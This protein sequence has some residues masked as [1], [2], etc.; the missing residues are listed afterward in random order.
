MNYVGLVL[1]VVFA[2]LTAAGISHGQV[3]RVPYASLSPTYGPLWVAESAGLFK[4]N[5]LDIQLIYIPSGSV[6][7][8]TL[9]SGEAKIAN[10]GGAAAINAWARGADLAIAAISS[11]RIL[12]V[13]M[14]PP[15][16]KRPEDLRGKRV[17]TDRYGSLSETVLREALRYYNLIPGKDVT[18]VQ[19]GGVPE[20]LGALQAGAADAALLTGDLKLQAEKLGFHPL[21][22]LSQLPLRYPSSAIV[23]T[24]SYLRGNKDVVKKFL[25]GWIEG[26]K[27]FKTD[28]EFTIRVLGRHLKSGDREILERTY[29]IYKDVHE[30][31]PHP[32]PAG[33][34][35]ALKRL[36]ETFPQAAKLGAEDLLANE[37]MAELESEGFIRAL[38]ADA[39]K[40]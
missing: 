13:V 7:V 11:D 18:I 17:A 32:H 1:G 27:V 20:R 3:L 29:D 21:I 31:A 22:D 30:T 28:R 19:S 40:R 6:I 39:A 10:M 12:H 24:R 16:M 4:K 37:V 15:K 26:I 5:N 8:P 14:A 9:L 2:C 36:A 33:V 35:F 38:Y 34:A 23:V 25:K